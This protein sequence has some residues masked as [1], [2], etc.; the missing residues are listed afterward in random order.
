[1][2]HKQLLA[3]FGMLAAASPLLAN[4]PDLAPMTAAPTASPDAK[5]CLRIEPVTGT[6]LEFVRCWTRQEWAE[7]DV[8]VDKEWAREGVAVVR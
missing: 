6:R 7:K 8:D 4:N 3:A 2:A 1:M 5:Y